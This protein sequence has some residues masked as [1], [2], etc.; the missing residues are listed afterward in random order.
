MY[1]SMWDLSVENIGLAH[2]DRWKASGIL[3]S[4]QHQ[5]YHS[6]TMKIYILTLTWTNWIRPWWA[7]WAILERAMLS[8]WFRPLTDEWSCKCFQHRVIFS[9]YKSA[10]WFA[11][12]HS[13]L[14]YFSTMVLHEWATWVLLPALP[15]KIGHWF[16]FTMLC[17][18]LLWETATLESDIFSAEQKHA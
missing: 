12:L 18:Q 2:V 13:A 1:Y 10:A 7:E 17:F 14:R 8:Y 6:L 11:A 3:S 5:I 16:S 15:I 4:F 9:K